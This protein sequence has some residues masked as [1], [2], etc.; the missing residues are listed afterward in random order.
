GFDPT[1]TYWINNLY[2]D[3]SFQVQG[4]ELQNFN[5]N[6]SAYGSAIYTVSVDQ[7]QVV[8]PPL[9]TIVGTEEPSVNLPDG[10]QLKQNYPNPFNPETT[11]AFEV[12]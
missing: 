11:I 3:T 7:E 5:V 12:A 2:S 10:F 1:A 4:S 8:L 6:L 9:P